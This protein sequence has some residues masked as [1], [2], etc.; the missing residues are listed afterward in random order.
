MEYM[1][2]WL[3]RN[4]S[5]MT[6]AKQ[7]GWC[8]DRLILNQ[9]SKW[10]NVKKSLLKAAHFG[11]SISCKCLNKNEKEEERNGGTRFKAT[12]IEKKLK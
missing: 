7:K 4:V 10:E 2:L 12:K 6:M 3:G 8:R 1:L 9:I 11:R 5:N